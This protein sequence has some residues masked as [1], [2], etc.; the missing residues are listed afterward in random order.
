MVDKLRDPAVAQPLLHLLSAVEPF[1]KS[2]MIAAAL[3]RESSAESGHSEYRSPQAWTA[4]AWSVALCAAEVAIA[5]SKTSEAA[6][7]D[8]V[9]AHSDTAQETLFALARG[10]HKAWRAMPACTPENG[11]GDSFEVDPLRTYSYEGKDLPVSMTPARCNTTRTADDPSASSQVKQEDVDLVPGT[12]LKLDT[13]P[14]RENSEPRSM[15][16]VAPSTPPSWSDAATAATSSPG[17]SGSVSPSPLPWSPLRLP[18]SRS[19]AETPGTRGTPGIS[20][21]QV[22]KEEYTTP[23]G[24]A[25][26]TTSQPRVAVSSTAH[27][28]ASHPKPLPTPPT[29]GRPKRILPAEYY[30]PIR[31]KTRKD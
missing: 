11:R 23:P 31:K 10:W 4:A 3:D 7:S 29:T 19:L 18:T 21:V 14:L 24:D 28:P 6:D 12:M 25:L 2:Q 22:K 26:L 17:V 27:S 9:P 13:E 1:A 30:S 15:L 16:D 5:L 20:A 8:S